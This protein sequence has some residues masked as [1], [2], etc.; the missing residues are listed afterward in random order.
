ME[1]TLVG[2]GQVSLVLPAILPFLSESAKASR[3][4][5]TVDDILRHVLNGRMQL[6]AVHQHG[7]V[8]GHV[9]TEVTQYP[10]CRMLTVQYTA[11]Q[12]GTLASVEDLLQ[13]TAHKYAQAAGCAG[14]EFIGRPGWAKTAKKHGYVVRSVM[15]QKFFERSQ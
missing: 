15:Y 7:H 9:I 6:W 2:P 3:G 13:H 11:M 4:R 10:Q 8:C 12:P 14:I 1:V 5:A